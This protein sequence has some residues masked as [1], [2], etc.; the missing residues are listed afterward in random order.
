[1]TS[2]ADPWDWLETGARLRADGRPFALVTVVAVKGSAP[3]GPG[4]KMIVLPNGEFHGTV[5]GGQLERLVL[6]D[7]RGALAQAISEP[8]KYPLCLRTGQCCG[9]AV[10]TFIEIVGVGPSLYLFG[11]GHVAQSLCQVLQGTPFTVHVIDARKEWLDHPALPA[12]VRRHEEPWEEFMAKASWHRELT[13][14][15]VMTHEHDLDLAVIA[16]LVKRPARFIGLI[17]SGTK[18]Q[19]F[20]QRLTALGADADQI[21]RVQCPIG[22]LELGKAPREVAI[23]VAAELL[24]L[25]KDA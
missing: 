16:E 10:E 18:W 4:A 20:Q 12:V 13:Y 15:A 7:A 22:T 14:A 17:G 5:G 11:A 25:G 8:K 9:G 21:A 24:R 19:R 3:R 2:G 1:M 23:S 6:D